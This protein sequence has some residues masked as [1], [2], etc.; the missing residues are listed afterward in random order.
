MLRLKPRNPLLTLP[1]E[2]GI[3]MINPDDGIFILAQL[4]VFISYPM[5]VMTFV[6]P[7]A[8]VTL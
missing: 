7:E 2:A 4:A 8:Q 3:S 1:G 5:Y 6:C